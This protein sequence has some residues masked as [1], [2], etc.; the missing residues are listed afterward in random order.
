M[1]ILRLIF[2]PASGWTIDVWFGALFGPLLT[3]AGVLE[4]I[5]GR[6]DGPLVLVVGILLSIATIPVAV[7]RVVRA[8]QGWNGIRPLANETGRHPRG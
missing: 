7:V 2:D 4:I 8:I 6:H 1:K 3:I 5:D